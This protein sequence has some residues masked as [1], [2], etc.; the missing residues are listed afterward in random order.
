MSILLLC[1]TCVFFFNF[2][3]RIYFSI[4]ILYLFF[5]L[6][7]IIFIFR[8]NFNAQDVN[9]FLDNQWESFL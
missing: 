7:E 5:Q 6:F 9:K 8:S 1:F 3:L 2:D 4:I